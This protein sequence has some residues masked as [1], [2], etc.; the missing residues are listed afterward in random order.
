MRS[1][2]VEKSCNADT[3]A[4]ADAE[5]R[6]MERKTPISILEVEI[7]GEDVASQGRLG[8]MWQSAKQKWN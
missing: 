5:R 7:D 1:G 4:D 8:L 2:A 3:D 6:W